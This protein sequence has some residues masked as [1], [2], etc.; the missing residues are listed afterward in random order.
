M[1]LNTTF[2]ERLTAALPPSAILRDPADL[3]TYES[4]ALVHL[5]ATPGLVVLPDHAK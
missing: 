2:L 3:L 4:D 1:P 5:R